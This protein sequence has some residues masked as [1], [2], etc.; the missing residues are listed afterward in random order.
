MLNNIALSLF[1]RVYGVARVILSI[2]AKIFIVYG[3]LVVL[4][5]LAADRAGEAFGSYAPWFAYGAGALIAREALDAL[6]RRGV[7]ALRRR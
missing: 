3:A 4:I 5:A 7:A 1:A 2:S 6:F